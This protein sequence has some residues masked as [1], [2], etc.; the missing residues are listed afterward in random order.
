MTVIVGLPAVVN[1]FVVPAQLLP[2]YPHTE[3]FSRLSNTHLVTDYGSSAVFHQDEMESPPNSENLMLVERSFE[4]RNPG[5]S[6]KILGFIGFPR[7]W[8]FD[9]SGAAA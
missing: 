8:T 3:P 6:G 5:Q 1:I 4:P 7:V 2:D 9:P